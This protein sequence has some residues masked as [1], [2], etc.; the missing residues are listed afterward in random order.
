M[1]LGCDSQVVSETSMVDV[2]RSALY[3]T[4]LRRMVF[5][6]KFLEDGAHVEYGWKS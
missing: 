4:E 1:V 5:L 6:L 2:Y 3:H